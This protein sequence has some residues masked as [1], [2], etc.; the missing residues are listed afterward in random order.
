MANSTNLSSDKVSLSAEI[1]AA[2]VTHNSINRGGHHSGIPGGIIPLH[3][4][5]FL[6]I[7]TSCMKC[8]CFASWPH[9]QPPSS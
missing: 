8:D 1:V 3:P 5:G 2:Y 7:G 6:G 9:S 4:G